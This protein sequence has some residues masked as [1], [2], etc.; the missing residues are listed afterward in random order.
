[1]PVAPAGI[2]AAFVVEQRQKTADIGVILLGN[3]PAQTALGQI[4]GLEQRQHGV[5]MISKPL[6]LDD[7]RSPDQITVELSPLEI[8]ESAGLFILDVQANCLTQIFA[9][10]ALK[11][12]GHYVAVDGGIAIKLIHVPEAIGIFV[13]RL[14]QLGLALMLSHFTPQILQQ[15]ALACIKGQHHPRPNQ[16]LSAVPGLAPG[17]EQGIALLGTGATIEPELAS[18]IPGDLSL[19]LAKLGPV[20][21]ALQLCGSGKFRGN[22]QKVLPAFVGTGLHQVPVAGTGVQG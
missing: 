18:A 22:G 2:V 8:A 7:K 3:S 11:P 9:G 21:I 14:Q 12:G 20:K 10:Q 17:I 16:F 1:M 15:A 13:Y 5:D 19:T 6:V 4:V